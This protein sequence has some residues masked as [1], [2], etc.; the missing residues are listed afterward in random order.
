MHGRPHLD[1]ADRFCCHRR[2]WR[3]AAA[4]GEVSSL[5]LLTS[6]NCIT[7]HLPGTGRVSQLSVFSPGGL[8]NALALRRAPELLAPWMS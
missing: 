4:C 8:D 5:C 1:M 3:A 7:Q 2:G 6:T